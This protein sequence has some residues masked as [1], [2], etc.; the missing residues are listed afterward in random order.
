MEFDVLVVGAGTGGTTAARF[1]AQAGLKVCLIDTKPEAKIGEKICGDAVGGEVF[2][3]LGMAPPKNEELSWKVRG[4]KLVSPDRQTCVMMED[5]SQ[6]GYIVNRREFGQ[7]LLKESLAAGS[8]DFRDR[9]FAREFLIEG[10]VVK[11][12][13]ARE[14]DD[15]KSTEIR[16]KITVDASGYHTPL[17]K[18]LNSPFIEQDIDEAQ[19]SILCY[20]EIVDFD[21]AGDFDPNFIVITLDQEQAPGGYLWHFPKSA[22]ALNVG[23]GTYVKFNHDLKRMYYNNAFLP[24]VNNRHFTIRTRGGGLVTVRR[25]IASAVEDGVMFVGDAAAQVNPLDG[26]GIDSSMRAGAL[27]A[28]AAVAAIQANNVTKVGLWLYNVEFMRSIGAQFGSLDILRVGLQS[29]T[30][31]ELNFGLKNHLL[32]SKDILDIAAKGR[33]ELNLF[34]MVTRAVRGIL[35]PDLLAT[36]AYI[37]RK[38]GEMKDLY[39]KYPETPQGFAAWNEKMLELHAGTKKIL[40]PKGN[41]FTYKPTQKKRQN[42]AFWVV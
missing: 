35:K 34:D 12:V 20:R 26:G 39:G 41:L 31:E 32:E 16:A 11:G 15:S 8:V 23:I 29:L 4:A 13:K 7:R 36:L 9:T 10:G 27:A 33:A 17:R 24:I 19:N 14:K 18:S 22:T 38:M 3:V 37:H 42:P 5:A 25:P 1:A 6:A 40:A 21:T 30:N 2:D 28:K